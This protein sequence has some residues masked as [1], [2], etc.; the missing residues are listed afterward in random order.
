NMIE[1]AIK[2]SARL[3]YFST[4]EIYGDPLVHPQSEEYFGNV[5]PIG[6]RS[7]YDEAKRFGEALV[8]QYVREGKL[9]AGII[10]IF[11]T[12]GPRLDPFDGRVISTFLRQAS[13]DEVL[14][15]NGSGEQTRSFCYISDLV[16]GILKMSKIDIMGPINLGNP[17]E[18]TLNELV[19]VLEKIF[20][21]ELQKTYL[22][23]LIDDP[24]RRRPDISKANKLLNWHP[25]ILLED[26]LKACLS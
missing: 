22:P 25:K 5:N 17:Y 2:N 26:G 16:D 9:N 14:T 20:K 10:R 23:G 8:S 12:Y 21:K 19:K 6:P 4:S 11:N 15:I 18:I 7:I 1:V 3:I 24:L 13:N